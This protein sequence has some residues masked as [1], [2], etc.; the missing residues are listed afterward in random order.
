MFCCVVLKF[1]YFPT[2][3]VVVVVY[4]LVCKIYLR[5]QPEFTGKFYPVLI[6][7][8]SR[9]Q[10][11]FWGNSEMIPVSAWGKSDKPIK[12]TNDLGSLWEEHLG[13]LLP[14]KVLSSNTGIQNH[15]PIKI[16]EK[17]KSNQVLSWNHYLFST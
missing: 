7:I 6:W 2:T 10:V 8:L 3:F 13:N 11:D 12:S 14:L 16:F 4:F 15:K 5:C 17:A 9:I 1:G